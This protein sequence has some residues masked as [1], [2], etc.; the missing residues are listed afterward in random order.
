MPVQIYAFANLK[1]SVTARA[2]P[3]NYFEVEL[4]HRMAN[5]L[6][7]Q[8]RGSD[9]CFINDLRSRFRDA[10][11]TIGSKAFHTEFAGFIDVVKD[12]IGLVDLNL[13]ELSRSE[14]LLEFLDAMA[15][16][17][18]P[19]M[20]LAHTI[21]QNYVPLLFAQDKSIPFT[22]NSMT[23]VYNPL[24]RFVMTQCV[25]LLDATGFDPVALAQDL[26]DQIV[27][28]SSIEA[29]AW[30]E[31]HSYM[32]RLYGEFASPTDMDKD[33]FFVFDT[34]LSDIQIDVRATG[35]PECRDPALPAPSV[36]ET[37]NET[38]VASEFEEFQDPPTFM[39]IDVEGDGY[40]PFTQPV[41]WGCASARYF[42]A[43]DPI[44]DEGTEPPSTLVGDVQLLARSFGGEP[45]RRLAAIATDNPEIPAAFEEVSLEQAVVAMDARVPSQVVPDTENVAVQRSNEQ[46]GSPTE[47]LFTLD[48]DSLPN[49]DAIAPGTS[50]FDQWKEN[51]IKRIIGRRRNANG[52]YDAGK[53][54]GR[55]FDS[56]NPTSRDR[57]LGSPNQ[58]CPG[59]TTTTCP[60]VSRKNGR[61]FLI[62]NST[63]CVPQFNVLILHGTDAS[64]E[65]HDSRYGG[66]LTFV[67]DTSVVTRVVSIELMDL[68]NTKGLRIRQLSTDSVMENL[69]VEPLGDN[70]V[71][72]VSLN[73][74]LPNPVAR[75]RVDLGGPGA[76]TKV[77]YCIQSGA[78]RFLR[79]TDK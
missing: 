17:N 10:T 34:T 33:P 26:K 8:G 9:A 51:G 39:R 2:V 58:N 49:G 59:C 46:C 64:D 78:R 67:F 42:A 48:F 3:V 66:H 47:Q 61:G 23:T 57:D 73:T 68:E 55:L 69:K 44:F 53:E 28:P 21:V 31:S 52:D 24:N 5:W 11:A 6:G 20:T 72:K 45:L 27:D 50:A 18:V 56:S 14:T 40:G 22:C 37:K 43:G 60:G 41:S 74:D 35:V 12:R 75:V 25:P 32:T 30:V 38:V 7:C 19:D 77:K 4:D 54:W 1:D 76:V 29:E 13:D 79:E 70:T 16:A 15:D 65:P 63:N 62:A 36:E 71:Q